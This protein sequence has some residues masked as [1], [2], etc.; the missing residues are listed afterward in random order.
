MKDEGF[1]FDPLKTDYAKN[2]EK[3]KLY[4]EEHGHLNI[5]VKEPFLG[6]FVQTIRRKYKDQKENPKKKF[7][8]LLTGEEITELKNIGFEFSSPKSE[9]RIWESH[10]KTF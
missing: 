8:N 5:P 3:L 9:D 6:P 2:V 1:D 10:Y 4:K 7:R